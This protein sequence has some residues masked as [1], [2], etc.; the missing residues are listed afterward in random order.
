LLD[1]RVFR[2]A[3]FSAA[4]GAISVAFFTLFG[5]IFLV[6][7][8]FQFVR[9]YST[10]SAGLHTLPFALFAAVTAPI[11]A[12]LALRFG[13]RRV[14]SSGLAA[15]MAGFIMIG[16]CKADTP[17]FGLVL[18]SMA[19]IATGLALVTAPSTAAVMA[20]LPKEKAGAGAAVNDTTRE[21]G[22]TLGVA[23]LGS[24]FASVY[25]PKVADFLG[26]LPVPA[27][28]LA[29]A[30]ESMAAA[31][32][33]VSRAPVEVQAVV[34]DGVTA[35]FMDGMQLACFV[36]AGVAFIGAVVSFIALPDREEDEAPHPGEWAASE[37]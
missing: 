23:V 24:V 7:Q 37:L 19:F 22:G 27:D 9:G 33:V 10:L 17:Y 3:R 2:I 16:L 14:V 21:I 34:R 30:K 26:G 32:E 5:F 36:A 20:S 1:V 15:M 6:T 31:I 12:R 25:A 28:A 4:A 29:A 11:G 35:A 8:Y 13:P 18:L